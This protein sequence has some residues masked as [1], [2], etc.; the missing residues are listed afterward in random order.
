[1]GRT[2]FVAGPF[3]QK[4]PYPGT[5][6]FRWGVDG[7]ADAKAKERHPAEIPQPEHL[8]R[9]GRVGARAGRAADAGDPRGNVLA[10]RRDES[11]QRRDRAP[12]TWRASIIPLLAVPVSI[13]GT[14]LEEER[15]AGQRRAA[16]GRAR[17][18]S[19]LAR[20]S[21]EGS[22]SGAQAFR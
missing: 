16:G 3:I 8:E 12:Q 19:G 18:A 11:R 6:A 4:A 13:V 10:S 7:A 14:S 15:H 21:H 17:P 9:T 22:R 2:L 20:T 5:E 1:M